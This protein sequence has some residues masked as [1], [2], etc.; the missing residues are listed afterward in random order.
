MPLL[1]ALKTFSYRTAPSFTGCIQLTAF[2]L[3]SAGIVAGNHIYNKILDRDW[4]SARLFIMVTGLSGVQ[5]GQKYSAARRILNSPIGVSVF[6]YPDETL[7]L[8]FD[9]LHVSVNSVYTS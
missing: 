3:G 9:I 6:G 2:S 7:S 5:F 8:V 1:A 4:F